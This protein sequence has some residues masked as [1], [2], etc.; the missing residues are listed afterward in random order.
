MEGLSNFERLV[1]ARLEEQ[2]HIQTH[3][4]DPSPGLD[5]DTQQRGLTSSSPI[6]NSPLLMA[7]QQPTVYQRQDLVLNVRGYRNSELRQ[8]FMQI[9]LGAIS[10][11]LGVGSLSFLC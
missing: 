4:G 8:V 7:L 2:Q 10:S 1:Q 5:N 6:A 3:G 9:T 11:I